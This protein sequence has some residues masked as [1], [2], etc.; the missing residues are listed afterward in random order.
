MTPGS[1]AGPDAIVRTSPHRF[2]L[3]DA[4]PVAARRGDRLIVGLGVAAFEWVTREQL[5]EHLVTAPLVVQAGAP[6]V[7][8]ILAA[9]SLRYL[10]HRATPS[11]ADEY[12]ENFHEHDEPLD[13]KPV[14]GRIAAGVAT[15][16]CGGALGFEGPSLYLGA[17]IGSGLQS[18]WRR[19]FSPSDT[20]VL[21][22]A[23]AAAGVAAIFK[24]PATGAIFAL[25][26][27]YQD[28]TAHRMLL[29]AL[30][31]AA[32]SYLTFVALVGTTPLFAVNG[33]PPFDLRDL[34]GALVLGLL[35]GFG[36]A[37]FS[38]L[39]RAA[40]R[41]AQ[42]GHPAIRVTVAG[43]AMAALFAGSYAVFGQGARRPRLQRDR[44]GRRSLDGPGAVARAPC[45]SRSPPMPSR[46]PLVASAD[47]SSHS[48][49]RGPSSVRSV[50]SRWVFPTRRCFRSSAWPRSSAPG[51][52]TPLAGVVFVAEA[53]GRAG[54]VVPGVI[55]SVM[56]QLM[57]GNES[58]SPYQQRAELPA[59]AA[60]RAD[61]GS[62]R[63]DGVM[64]VSARSLRFG[65]AHGR[66]H[67]R[68]HQSRE[69]GRLASV[70]QDHPRPV[71]ALER[72]RVR[73]FH[74]DQ[75]VGGAH[76]QP[77]V[78]G[79][80]LGD[81]V[82]VRRSPRAKKWATNADLGSQ[83]RRGAGVSHSTDEMFPVASVWWARWPGPPRR[84]RPA[85]PAR[86]SARDRRR[87]AADILAG[88]RGS[89]RAL[90]RRAR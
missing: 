35:C 77:F 73:R 42:L 37:G 28:D 75:G 49:S 65:S 45:V 44:V 90:A 72:P 68:R 60:R 62:A 55:A 53:T 2:H 88:R 61:G 64:P 20:K 46:W 9:L 27:P 76:H 67:E 30:I 86:R 10:A 11:T 34:G 59:P 54:F 84:E 69:S 82:A 70:A 40:K 39:V 56:A 36:R 17:A 7:G 29:P 6:F 3:P 5:Y 41:A 48:S 22:V 32:T 71:F 85:R 50:A 83:S 81:F 12:I 21:M 66:C 1:W 16:G 51:Y 63:F 8:F 58:V 18:R 79:R 38:I 74:R 43:A 78:S 80:V 23:G 24:T 47:S 87:R 14:L 33:T 52:R 19:W 31:A 25:E 15:L 26:V 4:P 13:L 57:M 89:N